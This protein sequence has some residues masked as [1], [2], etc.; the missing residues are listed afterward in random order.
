MIMY[1][2][3]LLGLLDICN[4]YCHMVIHESNQLS[5]TCVSRL[6]GCL[7]RLSIYYSWP[8]KRTRP[9]FRLRTVHIAYDECSV[10]ANAE[11]NTGIDEC[12]KKSSVSA[13]ER[14][15]P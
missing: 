8:K 14:R 1:A 7:G 15:T 11:S 5:T 12:Q 2:S 6:L 9:P 4:S 3:G 10:T 13:N